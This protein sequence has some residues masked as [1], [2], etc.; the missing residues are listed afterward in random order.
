M[1]PASR[2]DASGRT[3]IPREIREKLSLRP[4][5]VIACEV[6]HDEVRLRKRTPL[7]AGYLRAVQT[8]LG[9]WE[10]PEDAAAFDDL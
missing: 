3:T 2:I 10:S 7:D 1:Q 8:T 9:E 6:G 5:G 4:G